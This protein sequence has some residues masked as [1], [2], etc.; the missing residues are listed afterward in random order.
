M[1]CRSL[2]R[3]MISKCQS[4]AAR[5]SHPCSPRRP[6]TTQS[7]KGVFTPS[8]SSSTQSSRISSTSEHSSPYWPPSLQCLSTA[9]LFT[10]LSSSPPRT[11]EPLCTRCSFPLE[12]FHRLLCTPA[13]GT[14]QLHAPHASSAPKHLFSHRHPHTSQNPHLTSSLFRL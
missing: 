13:L 1:R 3:V 14:P 8:R 9:H 11:E 12:P 4:D 7:Q 5:R 10:G 2:P 6:L